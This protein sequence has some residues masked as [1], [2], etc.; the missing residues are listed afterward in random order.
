MR[1]SEKRNSKRNKRDRQ[2]GRV[3]EVNG[4]AEF[5][6]PSAPTCFLDPSRLPARL[7]SKDRFVH[8][9]PVRFDDLCIFGG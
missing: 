8:K 1:R 6:L 5:C 3:R 9:A 2:R 7:F 4:F